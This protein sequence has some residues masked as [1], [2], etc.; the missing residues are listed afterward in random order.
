MVVACEP[1]DAML[2][3]DDKYL[4]TT[5]GLKGRPMQLP[6][7]VHRIEL[8]KDGY[9]AH[10]AE[11]TIARGVQQKLAVKLRKQPF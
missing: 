5:G 3:V 8:R 1:A 11:I 9:F 2:F 7:G 6:E 10:L 4:G